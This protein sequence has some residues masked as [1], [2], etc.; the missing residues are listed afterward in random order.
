MPKATGPLTALALAAGAATTAAAQQGSPLSAQSVAD[1][2]GA[3]GIQTQIG[4]DD[5]G[6]PYVELTPGGALPTDFGYVQF[7]ECDQAGLCDSILMVA[8]YRPQRRPVHLDKI[9]Q[10]NVEHRWIRAYVDSENYV[11]VD[12]DLSGYGGITPDALNT[13]VTRFVGSVADF[14][15]FIQR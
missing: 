6:D 7:W 13:Q 15:A 12:M 4:T 8:G 5:Y 3:L 1:A 9:N 2:F 11:I 10:W 14:A